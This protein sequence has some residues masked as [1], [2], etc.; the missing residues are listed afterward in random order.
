VSMRVY[1][2]VCLYGVC[3]CVCMVCVC[4]CVCP[5]VQLEPKDLAEQLKRGGAAIPAIRPGRQT[6]EYVT[7]TLTRMSLLGSVFLGEDGCGVTTHHN[8][9]HQ[10][11]TIQHAQDNTGLSEHRESWAQGLRSS[12]SALCACANALQT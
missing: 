11:N 4:V 7:N 6:A 2:C 1:T 12:N 8:T 5:H 9:T 3:V 10:Y